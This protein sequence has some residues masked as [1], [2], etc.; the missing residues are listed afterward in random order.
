MTDAEGQ[1]ITVPESDLVAAKVVP[2]PPARRPRTAGLVEP[3]QQVGDPARDRDRG[4]EGSGPEGSG[5]E[6]PGAEVRR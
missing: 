2:P 1:V 3:N 6:G 4:T 5:P